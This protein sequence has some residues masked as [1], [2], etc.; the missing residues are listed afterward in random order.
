MSGGETVFFPPIMKVLCKALML[1]EEENAA[2]IDVDH[3]LAALDTP[4]TVTEPAERTLGP[5]LPSPHRGKPLSNGAKAAIEAAGA[6][7]PADL[8]QLTP[9]SLRTA[10]LAV[11]RDQGA[12][13]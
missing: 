1:A 10:L 7:A 2:E 12:R 6:L 5:Y 3:V 9:D 8:G 11:K 4:V 13:E